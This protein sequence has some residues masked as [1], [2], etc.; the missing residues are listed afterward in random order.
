[1]ANKYIITPDG[2]FHC[3]SENELYHWRWNKKDHKYVAKVGEGKNTRYFYSLLE[4][5]AYLVKQK[6]GN[7]KDDLFSSIK[8][9]FSSTVNKITNS[10]LTKINKFPSKIDKLVNAG[11]NWMSKL[12]DNKNNIY[13]V[14][15]QSYNTKI[16]KIQQTK[17]WKDIVARSDPEYVKKT[18]DGKTHYLIDEYV[19]NKKHPVLDII[20]DIA[21]GRKV[22]TNKI[23]KDTVVAGI[24][25]YTFGVVKTGALVVSLGAKA[26]TEKY[27]LQQGSYDDEIAYVSDMAT[28]GAAYMRDSAY[29]VNDSYVAPLTNSMKENSNTTRKKIDEKKVV[30]AAREIMGSD[31]T[32]TTMSNVSGLSDEEI[33]ALYLLL[34]GVRSR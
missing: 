22:T 32:L 23:T 26:L 17:E 30:A 13:E 11:K 21:A 27:K 18:S 1:M 3:V 5:Q 2:N 34:N 12:Y 8:S 24:K 28:R 29:T 25:D 9:T 7:K 6:L 10:L 31:A 14:T 19:V 15:S 16:E 20:G 4:Y 33:Q